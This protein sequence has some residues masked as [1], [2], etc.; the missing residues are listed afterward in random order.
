MVDPEAVSVDCAAAFLTE[1]FGGDGAEVTDV[2]HLGTGAWSKAFAF[3]HATD[4]LVIRFGA[5][6]D[7]FD[8]DL[9]AARFNGPGLPVPRVL[10]VGESDAVG[11]TGREIG[12]YYAI[13][14]R[15]HGTYIDDVD[16]DQLRS[17]LPS[18]F[19]ALDAMRLADISDT[20]GYGMWGADGSAPFS[21]WRE[22]L[23]H[24]AVDDPSRRISGWRERLAGCPTGIGP[25][26]EAY[27]VLR[28]THGRSPRARHLIH[29]DLLHWNVLVTG[30][31]ITGVFDWGCGM[32]GDFL[33]DLAW[34]CF[35][36]PW[37]PTWNS[38]SFEEEAV[39]H[40]ARIGL[41]MPAFKERLRA[42]MIHIGL[43]GQSYQAFVGR[44]D[45]VAETARWTLEIARGR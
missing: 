2:T 31:Q 3:R 44:W 40:F 19:G 26:E 42:C 10:E 25:F 24:A 9:R 16:A 12:G 30:D 43:D 35:W 13:S 39:K 32:Y 45:D 34:C 21:S 4:E 17:L 1:R 33:Y 15:L 22:F 23:L 41:D 20:I 38:I 6:R 28:A 27:G 5:Q 29:S 36:A 14:Q 7:D 11:P 18:L 8:K 37:Y